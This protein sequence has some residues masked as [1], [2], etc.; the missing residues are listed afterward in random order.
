MLSEYSSVILFMFAVCWM[1][2]K[3]KI[4]KKANTATIIEPKKTPGTDGWL[5]EQGL[6]KNEE[7][8]LLFKKVSADLKTQENTKNETLWEIGKTLTHP[9]WKPNVEECGEGKFHACSRPYF[10]DEFRN[11]KGDKYIVVKINIKDLY[12][13]E[14]DPSYP[15]KVAFREGTVLYECDKFGKQK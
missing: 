4:E 14:V 12:V 5:Q 2:R 10:C 11:Q 9:S 15:H 7:H 3:G 13:W 1:I 6:E 8:V